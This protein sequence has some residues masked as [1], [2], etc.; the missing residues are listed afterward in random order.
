[1]GSRPE[2]SGSSFDE[3][4]AGLAESGEYTFEQLGNLTLP[5]LAWACGVRPE[6]SS[7]EQ[8]DQ[9]VD[10]EYDRLWHSA[11][12]GVVRKFACLPY[13]LLCLDS[14]MVCRVASGLLRMPKDHDKLSMRIRNLK[15][16]AINPDGAK[17][18]TLDY[19][20]WLES[21]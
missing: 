10:A 19:L 9:Q 15:R 14:T 17:R 4:L 13:E 3:V 8:S 18:A 1:V 16:C 12:A 21:R 20:N 2:E 11:M 6:H 7:K 5:Q